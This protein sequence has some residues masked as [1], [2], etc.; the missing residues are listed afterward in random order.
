MAMRMKKMSKVEPK[1]VKPD[2]WE[3]RSDLDIL[4]RA[5]EIKSDSKRMKHVA[6]YAQKEL[7]KTQ[8]VV[9]GVSPVS[10]SSKPKPKSQPRR[11]R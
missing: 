3:L 7:T 6:K 5:E 11:K 4:R 8:K 1:L 2:E 10:S 9:S